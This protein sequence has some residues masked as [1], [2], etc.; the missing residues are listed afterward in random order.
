MTLHN[1]R[2]LC[3]P[4]T[5]LRDGRVC[6]L[7]LG[8]TPWRG[9][10][11]ACYRESVAG[12]A[13]LATSLTLHQRLGSFDRVRVYLALSEFVRRKY[14]TAGF[15]PE[16][17]IVKPNFAWDATLRSGPGEYFLFAGRLAPEKDV[18]TVIE[19]V[20]KADARLVIAGTGPHEASL[21]RRAPRGVDF[22]GLVSPDRVQSLTAQARAVVVPALSYEA[23]P[24]SV[25]E[26]FAAGVPVVAND[27]GAL[28]ELVE[29]GGTGL[30][31]PPGDPRALGS[32]LR[33]LSDDG[34]SERMGARARLSWEARYSPREGLAALERV[35]AAV[36]DGQRV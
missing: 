20:R 5:M 18:A 4:A 10:V 21:R 28:P 13:A 23:S 17:V 35:Y 26:A 9:I 33:R 1:Y 11:H 14:L 25:L 36:L 15:A 22:L 7:C 34:E 32:C 19:A 24:M 3:L 16:R 31:V 29:D 27:V 8:K 12:S 30:L 6:E 2:M